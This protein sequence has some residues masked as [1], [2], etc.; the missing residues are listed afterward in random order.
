MVVCTH[1]SK[2]TCFWG[3]L[4]STAARAR[5]ARGIVIDGYARDVA[6]ITAMKFPTFATGIGM[7]D[8]AG[9]RIPSVI[10]PPHHFRY[11]EFPTL[12]TSYTEGSYML[13]AK[14]DRDLYTY[15]WPEVAE[16]RWLPSDFERLEIDYSLDKVYSD[17]GLDIR[18]IRHASTS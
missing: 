3:E 8:S 12:G 2:R 10:L 18:Y 14:I 16:F 7:V 6:Q 11:D 4:L 1:Q 13:L 9:R 15:V 5:G 17:R